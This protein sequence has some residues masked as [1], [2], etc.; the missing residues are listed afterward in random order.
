MYGTDFFEANVAKLA[1]SSDGG[2]NGEYSLTCVGGT[3]SATSAFRMIVHPCVEAIDL[4]YNVI[5][6]TLD[7][8][9]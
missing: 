7:R 6:S 5:N 9:V 8:R 2:E 3:M 4:R 1:L